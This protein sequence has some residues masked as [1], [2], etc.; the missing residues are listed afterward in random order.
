MVTEVR[1]A[2]IVQ[3]DGE[4]LA[5]VEAALTSTSAVVVSAADAADVAVTLASERNVAAVVVDDVVDDAGAAAIARL[6]APEDRHRLLVVRQGDNVAT[7]V[8]WTVLRR[9]EL[10]LTLPGLVEEAEAVVVELLASVRPRQEP[11]ASPR[12]GCVVSVGSHF[13]IVA[14]DDP[15]DDPAV[16]FV[17]P[18]AGRQVVAGVLEPVPGRT[19]LWRLN[20]DDE[21]VRA[22]LLGF[23]LRRADTQER[24][25]S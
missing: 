25:L 23:T 9:S 15:P 3:A 4:T 18:G 17:L 19:G 11:T 21:N 1:T 10:R 8:A 2:V 24:L 20:P 5:R 13:L 22:A 6:M 12:I 7:D 16:S 14:L